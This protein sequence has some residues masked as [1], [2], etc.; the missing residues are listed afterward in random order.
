MMQPKTAEWAQLETDFDTLA[1]QWIKETGFHSNDNFI[2][3]H[4][5]CRE[6][7]A[8]G[9]T[10]LPLIFGRLGK[11]GTAV[12]WHYVLNAITGEDPTP[13][14]R[15]IAAGF[16]ALDI[17]AIHQAWLQWGREQGFGRRGD[18]GASAGA[19]SGAE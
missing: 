8:M 2:V 12:H 15:S 3:N 18:P 11:D 6:I 16:V 1:K 13:T 5:L 17:R 9:E 4:P 7:V 10:V 14:P 19:E